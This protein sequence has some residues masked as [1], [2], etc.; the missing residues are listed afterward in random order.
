MLDFFVDAETHICSSTKNDKYGVTKILQKKV[1]NWYNT[2][3]LHMGVVG[4]EKGKIRTYIK[5][6][7]NCQTKQ[8]GKLKI[9]KIFC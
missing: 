1:V 9:W 8:K 3:L 4:T 7:K 5:V 2:Y 6:C